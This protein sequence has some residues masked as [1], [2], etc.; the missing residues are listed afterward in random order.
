MKSLAPSRRFSAPA[1]GFVPAA[2]ASDLEQVRDD[3]ARAAK[4]AI[5]AGFDAVEIHLGHGYL[6]SSFMSPRLNLI[7]KLAEVLT[8]QKY[9]PVVVGN[10]CCYAR[11]FLEYLA[12]RDMPVTTVTPQQVEQYL[13]YAIRSF[14][15]CHGRPP[16]PHWHSIPRS[17]IHALLR[18]AQGQWPP[19]LKV[20][21]PDATLRQAICHAYETWLRDE[22]GLAT[23]SIDALMWE[24]RHFLAW[25]LDRGGAAS[26]IELSVRDID[27]YMDTRTPGPAA[28]IAEGCCRTASFAAAL[29][30]PDRARP[31][32]SRAARHCAPALRLRRRA[33]DTGARPDRRGAGGDEER[34]LANGAARLCD[35][36]A[37]RDLW[38]AVRR[39]PEPAA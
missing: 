36:A 33:I 6:L 26:L 34:Y 21:G 2:S 3:F 12:Q 39:N 35:A 29:H 24:A 32:R 25:Q 30:V 37:S 23:A 1:K 13:R 5:E 38:V 8:H 19:A 17:G 11:A 28:Q 9:S 16:G 18:L 22:R 31:D 27:L 15:K 4:N 14:R 20:I 7:A 10:Y